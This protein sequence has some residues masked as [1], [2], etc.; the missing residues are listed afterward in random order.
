MLIKVSRLSLKEIVSLISLSLLWV[1]NLID[2]VGQGIGV[3]YPS[4]FI[5][6]LSVFCL[7]FYVFKRLDKD[8]K[9]FLLYFSIYLPLY[10]FVLMVISSGAQLF[11]FTDTSYISSSFLF[12]FTILVVNKK[13]LF[14]NEFLMKITLYCLVFF[15]VWV[16]SLSYIS[17][18]GEGVEYFMKSG[19]LFFSSRQY[20]GIKLPYIY[21][22][23][24]PMLILLL[25]RNSWKIFI[26]FSVYRLVT[27]LLVVV[28]LA[29]SGTRMNI[30]MSVMT[31]FV[32]FLWFQF[33]RLSYN[34]LV[35]I[36][37]L[38]L[39]LLF[40]FLYVSYSSFQSLF[41]DAFS[42]H[43]ISNL[44]KID[45]LDLMM[46]IF[47][48]PVFFIFGQGFN[49]YDWSPLTQSLIGSGGATKTELTYFEFIRVFGVL[50]FLILLFFFIRYIFFIKV[51]NVEKKWV[52]PGLLCYLL[53]STLNPYLFSLNGVLV[54]GTCLSS[55]FYE[56][57]VY[58]VK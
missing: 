29:L 41:G 2:P 50:N 56:R 28:A 25:A 21:F 36:V 9:A 42:S 39:L 1:A 54:L 8:H 32:V 52:Q 38:L 51:T 45:D 7:F 6:F 4:Y 30:L 44:K 31:V 5:L 13:T 55:I 10:G 11:K 58:V 43:D 18:G 47:N 27:V 15:I 49:A 33:S 26:K 23:I 53:A 20:G 35:S 14:I 57:G 40:L 46:T 34:R 16:F 48:N 19:M 3:K 17:E 24:S 12:M 22:I 37:S